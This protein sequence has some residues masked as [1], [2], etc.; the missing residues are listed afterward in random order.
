MTKECGI[1]S[2]ETS[3]S[4]NPSVKETLLYKSSKNPS[5]KERLDKIGF[6]VVPPW[7]NKSQ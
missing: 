7:I 5:V 3:L 6:E 1:E 2:S 4:H